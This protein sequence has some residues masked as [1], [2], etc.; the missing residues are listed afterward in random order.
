METESETFQNERY[1]FIF[2]WGIYCLYNITQNKKKLYVFDILKL[3]STYT[4]NIL[5]KMW[6]FTPLYYPTYL[7]CEPLLFQNDLH[8]F[9]KF[10]WRSKE[11]SFHKSSLPEITGQFVN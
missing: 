7:G 6:E 9:S 3:N 10:V 2:H 5:S 8:K 4:Y 11:K 1:I